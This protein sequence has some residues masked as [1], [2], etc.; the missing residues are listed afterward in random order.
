L[1]KPARVLLTIRQDARR[2]QLR[3]L[4]Q[5]Q[6]DIIVVAEEFDPLR[7]LVAVA[8]TNADVVILDLPD[9]GTDP[10][11]CSHLLAEF[12]QLVVLALSLQQDE[13][14]VYKNKIIKERISSPADKEILSIIRQAR[15]DAD[16][17]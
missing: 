4:L 12:P 2:S 9:G 7:I 10:G 16:D 14:V 5:N 1:A 17:E 15:S 11:I 3:R 13:L 6:Q 8:E